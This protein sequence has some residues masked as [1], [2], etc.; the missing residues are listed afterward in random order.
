[1]VAIV[2]TSGWQ[3]DDWKDVLYDGV[4]KARWL[5]YYATVFPAVEVNNTFYNLPKEK[6]FTD[7]AT[8][9]PE[10]FVFVCKASRYITHIRRL[11]DVADPVARFVERASLLGDKLGAVLYQFPPSMERDDDR[12]KVF[13]DVL[14]ARPPA[15]IEFRNASWY[16]E[17]VYALMRSH[18]VALCVA[19]SS[20]HRTPF[21]T[22]AGWAYLRLHGTEGY[23]LYDDDT[24]DA[25]AKRVASLEAD[26]I[27]VFFDNDVAGNAVGNGLRL[28]TV[29]E[30]L[31]VPV[32]RPAATN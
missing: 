23:G 24:I 29:V 9:T 13:L 26:P 30:N 7:W 22:T 16:D 17:A 19:D 2:G 32:L 20:K 28:T 14:P 15:A 6:T 31:G 5:E 4:P 10:G 8:R 27:Y 25:W 3:Y 18:D 1:M 11:S 21:V 12:L